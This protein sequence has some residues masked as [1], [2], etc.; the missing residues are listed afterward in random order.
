V[1]YLLNGVQSGGMNG[2]GLGALR[3]F[4]DNLCAVTGNLKYIS[5]TGEKHIE[6]TEHNTSMK[7]LAARILLNYM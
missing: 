5:G 4:L 2:T 7:G 1:V 3:E 6:I